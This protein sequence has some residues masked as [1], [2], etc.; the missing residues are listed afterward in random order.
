MSRVPQRS[1]SN[2]RSDHRDLPGD[3]RFGVAVHV[4]VGDVVPDLLKGD[5]IQ[6][7]AS[8]LTQPV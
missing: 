5:I 3:G 8:L 7:K 4:E 2:E 1:E 6:F